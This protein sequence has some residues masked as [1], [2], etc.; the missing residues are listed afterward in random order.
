MEDKSKFFFTF[1]SLFVGG[2]ILQSYLDYAD[3]KEPQFYLMMPLI[4]TVLSIVIALVSKRKTSYKGMAIKLSIVCIVGLI[5]W[6]VLIMYLMA[7][8]KAYN[9]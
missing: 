1:L 3:I 8:G 5:L 9:H 6:T 7:L 2:C 4:I